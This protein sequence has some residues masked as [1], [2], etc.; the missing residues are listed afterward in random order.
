MQH[1]IPI[2]S[3]SVLVEPVASPG[4]STGPSGGSGRGRR[5]A[6]G[7]VLALAL[8][9]SPAANAQAGGN[10][11]NTTLSLTTALTGLVEGFTFAGGEALWGWMIGG[12]QSAGVGAIGGELDTIESTLTT[13]ASDLTNIED[14]LEE[15]NCGLDVDFIDQYA[16][17]IQSYYQ[18]YA[19]WLTDMCNADASG[20]CQNNGPLP[21]VDDVSEWANCAVGLPTSGQS[22]Q[23]DE[24]L[25]LLDELNDAA[26][27]TAG[28][29]GSIS[30]CIKTKGAAPAQDSV[31]DR[32]Y[33]TANVVPIT[34]WYL[35][36]DTHAMV[37]LTEAYHF[38]AWQAAGS[39]S[40]SSA[41]EI[42]AN[43]CST[44]STPEGCVEPIT[45]YSND[46]LGIAKG[47]LQ[48]GGAPYSTDEYLMANGQD[49]LIARSIEQYNM[50]ADPDNTA[51]CSTT[52]PGELTS[53]PGDVCGATVGE[54]DAAFS[55]VAYGPYGYGSGNGTWVSTPWQVF[56]NISNA[57][58]SSAPGTLLLT[59]FLCT[60]ST[61][62]GDAST[63]TQPNGGLGLFFGKKVVVHPE[64]DFDSW[65]SENI[66]NAQLIF[67]DGGLERQ[68]AEQ[69][70][71]ARMSL[72]DV[73][74]SNCGCAG[75]GNN[76]R[77]Q[78]ASWYTEQIDPNWYEGIIC[79]PTGFE[80]SA[81]G[82]SPPGPGYNPPGTYAQYRW[83]ALDWTEL[84]CS[85]DEA[86]NDTSNLN[87]AGVPSLCGQD[88]DAWF[89]TVVPAG[90]APQAAVADAT[91]SRAA[92]N[93]NDGAGSRLDVRGVHALIAFDQGNGNVTEHDR[94]TGSGVTW[95]CAED[96]DISDFAQEC[97][98]DWP[99]LIVG[100]RGEVVFQEDG[101]MGPVSWDV[102]EDVE[103]GASAWLLARWHGSGG[104]LSY[105]SREGAAALGKPSLTPTLVLTHA[106]EEKVLTEAD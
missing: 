13:I 86:A 52:E 70:V 88:F 99:R 14:E 42:Y 17:P 18:T 55:S 19:N 80:A 1:D 37:V 5:L 11:T 105:Y 106:N 76:T 26:S 104:S 32:P 47:Q 77:A 9:W 74:C 81:T 15:L 73:T 58:N 43:V 68:F 94:G 7:A 57:F 27:A 97:A 66:G 61:S 50:A 103:R 22:C 87:P 29:S 100:W 24:I 23:D 33:Y 49:Y 8:A 89:E 71:T 54:Y 28:A 78:Q 51:G 96:A 16:G 101:Y 34:D 79:L 21:S 82:W 2:R 62:G 65:I 46:F 35:G 36:I 53:A 63:C 84:A 6:A 59:S 67:T 56:G 83:P 44:G 30:D 4:V 39:P 20:T 75:N 31:D 12:G 85:N 98:Q 90:P 69:P 38:R 102:T 91:I 10:G 92:P 95:N 93:T 25:T 40:S 72:L 60:M 48:A 41:D 3:R 64:T 45:I